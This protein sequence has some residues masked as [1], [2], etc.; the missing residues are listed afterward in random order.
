MNLVRSIILVG[1]GIAFVLLSAS[2]GAAQDAA[3]ER[4][5]IAAFVDAGVTDEATDWTFGVGVST[6]FP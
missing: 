4:E 2:S 6:R 5:P 3:Q 1:S